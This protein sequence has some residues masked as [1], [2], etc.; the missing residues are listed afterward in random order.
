MDKDNAKK[1]VRCGNAGVQVRAICMPCNLT[2][3]TMHSSCEY[4]MYRKTYYVPSTEGTSLPWLLA[5]G[6]RHEITLP[7]KPT[8]EPAHEQNS[9]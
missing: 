4:V 6:Y 9:S 8:K 1:C 5:N 2:L 3:L 7:S